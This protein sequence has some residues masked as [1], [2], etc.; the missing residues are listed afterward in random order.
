MTFD[1]LVQKFPVSEDGA[2]LPGCVNEP[3][4]GKIPMD[5]F[6]MNEHQI[7]KARR[8][9]PFRTRLYWRG[10]RGRAWNTARE[11]ATGVVIYSV[12]VTERI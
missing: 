4:T 2:R 9:A 8:E 3:L 12:N 5:Y 6:L 7:R 11:D 10:P 1:Q